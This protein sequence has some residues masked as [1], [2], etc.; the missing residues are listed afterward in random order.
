MPFNLVIVKYV[1]VELQRV[2]HDIQSILTCT[3]QFNPKK[4]R[5]K[6]IFSDRKSDL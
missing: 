2:R 5:F 4:K 1:Q 3:S 6:L